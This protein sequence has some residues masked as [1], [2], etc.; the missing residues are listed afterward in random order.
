MTTFPA[1]QHI[2][3]ALAVPRPLSAKASTESRTEGCKPGCV[4]GVNDLVAMK[5]RQRATRSLL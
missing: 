2:A 1:V 4:A 5:C 3:A